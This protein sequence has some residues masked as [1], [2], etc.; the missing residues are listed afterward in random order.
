MFRDMIAIMKPLGTNLPT[1]MALEPALG[2]RDELAT[3]AKS[4][5]ELLERAKRLG[6]SA[7]ELERMQ[8]VYGCDWGKELSESK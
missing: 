2:T 6:F 4:C 5:A 8:E 1:D 7:S 3:E